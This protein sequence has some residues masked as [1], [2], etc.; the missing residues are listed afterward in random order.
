[1]KNH[2]FKV[3]SGHALRRCSWFIG[4][5]NN[6]TIDWAR[7]RETDDIEELVKI[8]NHRY[9]D[10]QGKLTDRA[11]NGWFDTEAEAYAALALYLEN[12]DLDEAIMNWIEGKNNTTLVRG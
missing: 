5:D 12:N 9:I 7:F 8:S 4:N 6:Q 10:T 2:G 3:Y 11:D 1:M